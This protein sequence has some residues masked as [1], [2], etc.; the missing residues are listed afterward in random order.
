[1]MKPT[2]ALLLFLFVLLLFLSATS[3]PEYSLMLL[4]AEIFLLG[5]CLVG[6]GRFLGEQKTLKEKWQSKREQPLGFV[7]NP[8]RRPA[9][10]ISFAEHYPEVLQNPAVPLLSLED[11]RFLERLHSI[12]EEGQSKRRAQEKELESKFSQFFIGGIFL[13]AIFALVVILAR[14]FSSGASYV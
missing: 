5:V 10:L 12:V 9:E 1:M 8:N 7:L 3:P 11:P 14:W 4:W 2:L 13:P 6:A